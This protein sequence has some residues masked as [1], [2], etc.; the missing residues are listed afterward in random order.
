MIFNKNVNNEWFNSAGSF[1]FSILYL[2]G[3]DRLASVYDLIMP[4]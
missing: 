4:Q 1:L 2:V 3:D